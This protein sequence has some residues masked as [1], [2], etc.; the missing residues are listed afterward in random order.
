MLILRVEKWGSWW[1]KWGGRVNWKIF[2]VVDE[3]NAT[4]TG[5]GLSYH[6]K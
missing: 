1:N 6:E 3:G 4:A 2:M 5:G